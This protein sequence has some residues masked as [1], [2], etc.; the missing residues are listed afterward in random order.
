[1]RGEALVK[2]T[3]V[4]AEKIMAPGYSGLKPGFCLSPAEEERERVFSPSALQ[5]HSY[6]LEK[7]SVN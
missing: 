1:M 7:G 4:A 6:F 5:I 2:F 3:E